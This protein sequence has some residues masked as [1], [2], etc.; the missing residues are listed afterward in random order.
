MQIGLQHLSYYLPQE[1]VGLEALV[2]MNILREEEICLYRDVLGVEVIHRSER[3][4]AANIAVKVAQQALEESGISPQ[5]IDAVIYYH[6]IYLSAVAKGMDP[7]QKIQCELGLDKAIGCSIWGQGC[8]SGITALRVA[9]DMIRSGSAETVLIVGADSLTDS[10][11]RQIHGITIQG[12]GGSA[13]IVQRDCTTNRI[14]EILSRDEGSFYKIAN[15]TSEEEERYNWFFYMG[16]VRLVNKIIQ[17]GSLSLEEISLIIPHNI[18]TSSWARI[19]NLL[20]VDQAKIYKD[21]IPLHGHVFGSD[22]VINLAD[23]IRQGR[24]RRGEYALLLSAGLGASWG[25]LIV[26]H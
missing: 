23:A 24:I 4:T 14:V 12:D 22:I 17:R 19:A 25:G 10:H 11:K 1:I 15:T 3:E 16:T 21:N 7:I 18:N 6:T 26:Q 8:A 9:R 2:R 5:A 13:V 20:K